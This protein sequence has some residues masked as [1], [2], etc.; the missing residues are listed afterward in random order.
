[1][2]SKLCDACIPTHASFLLYSALHI[3]LSSV[4]IENSVRLRH[5]FKYFWFNFSLRTNYTLLEFLSFHILCFLKGDH[6]CLFLCLRLG[7]ILQIRSMPFWKGFI[8]LLFAESFL[9][10]NKLVLLLCCFVLILIY[11]LHYGM[12][13]HFFWDRF[14]LV[15]IDFS[16]NLI[17]LKIR[18]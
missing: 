17:I 11:Y 6:F 15:T 4:I 9:L 18:L 8:L 2:W 5:L 7:Q 13:F 16:A 14:P 1:M 12:L 3:V 10:L